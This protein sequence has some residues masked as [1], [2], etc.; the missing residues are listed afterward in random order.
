MEQEIW[1][2]VKG[3]EGLYEVS[4]LGRVMY[5]PHPITQ[6]AASGTVFTRTFK[7]HLMNPCKQR[8]GYLL[9]T[10]HDAEYR[11]RYKLVH[12]IVAEAFLENPDN[13]PC[14]NHKDEDRT[15]NCV[16]NLEW[17]S[18]V[19]N[20]NYGT[21]NEKMAAAF[22]KPTG[23]YDI[24][25]ALVATYPSAKDAASAN[26]IAWGTLRNALSGRRKDPKIKGFIYRYL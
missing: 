7:K 6:K 11:Q 1:K 10:L 26:N 16:S 12:R 19:Y 21:R 25:G 17:C 9:C 18:Y 24:S 2:P 4:N 13:L 5:V 20:V 3:F 14:I 8:T 15:N 22:R 23:K